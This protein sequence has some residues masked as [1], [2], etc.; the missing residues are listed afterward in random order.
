MFY[1]RIVDCVTIQGVP[2]KSLVPS[3]VPLP[4]KHRT[5]SPGMHLLHDPKVASADGLVKTDSCLLPAE[6]GAMVPP[7]HEPSLTKSVNPTDQKTLR[8]RIKMGPDN[9][10]QKNAAI[11]IGLGLT[12]PSSSMG[13]SPKESGGE[14]FES[15]DTLDE[16]PASILQVTF[17]LISYDNLFISRVVPS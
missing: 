4:P 3:D 15:Q 7:K 8:V 12:S 17:Y 11:Y 2:Q 9:A 10:A 16:S 13:H 6:V 14:P 5:T 1:L